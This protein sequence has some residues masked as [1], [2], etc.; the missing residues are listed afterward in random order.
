M[1]WKLLQESGYP[2]EKASTNGRDVLCCFQQTNR[3]SL[4]GR[5]CRNGLQNTLQPRGKYSKYYNALLKGPFIRSVPETSFEAPPGFPLHADAATSEG[6]DRA[7]I[8]RA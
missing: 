6:V 4:Y 5:L 7:T 8:H 1:L 2:G 3:T